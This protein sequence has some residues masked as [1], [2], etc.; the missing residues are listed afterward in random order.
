M[1]KLTQNTISRI[2]GMNAE[3]ASKVGPF[4][5]VRGDGPCVIRHVLG[6]VSTRV[7]K[8]RYAAYC[9]YSNAASACE[10]SEKERYSTVADYLGMG[11][12]D[13]ADDHDH[14]TLGQLQ[15]VCTDAKTRKM[16]AK[17]FAYAIEHYPSVDLRKME[18]AA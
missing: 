11:A 1:Q 15:L 10:G 8:S 9:F 17:D 4:S 12:I 3:K 13:V 7:W 6:N 16:F 14:L 2:C 5:N 18:R